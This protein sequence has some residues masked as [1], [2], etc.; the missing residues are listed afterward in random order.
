MMTSQI[1]AWTVLQARPFYKFLEYRNDVFMS[2]SS[3][4]PNFAFFAY[5]Q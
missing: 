2:S 5:P 1:W 4:A 3:K